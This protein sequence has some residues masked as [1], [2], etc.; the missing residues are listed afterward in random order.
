MIRL[1]VFG[2]R[3]AVALAL[4]SLAESMIPAAASEQQLYENLEI[5]GAVECEVRQDI[6]TLVGSDRLLR[7]VFKPRGGLP[8]VEK[9]YRGSVRAVDEASSHI[10][11]DVIAWTVLALENVDVAE[12]SD[13]PIIGAYSPACDSLRAEYGLKEGS[14]FGGVGRNIAL[15][16]R[17]LEGPDGRSNIAAAIIAFELSN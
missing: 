3:S 14:L 17:D 4:M 7:C 10:G 5:K 11:G 9:R 12:A 16:P 2:K 15:E 13:A 8:D 6:R 1:N